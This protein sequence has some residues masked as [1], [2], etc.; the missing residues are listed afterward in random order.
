[1]ID[2]ERL[3]EITYSVPVDIGGGSGFPKVAVMAA[4]AEFLGLTTYIEVGVYRGRSFLPL[5]W[6]FAQRGGHSIAVDPYSRDEADEKGLPDDIREAVAAFIA[7][8]DW[9]SVYDEFM[10]RRSALE[11]D[12]STTVFRKASSAAFPLVAEKASGSMMIHID[13]NHDTRC[14]MEDVRRYMSLM[15]DGDVLVLDDTDWESVK[16]ALGYAQSS[17]YTIHS[18]DTFTILTRLDRDVSRRIRKLR[19]KCSEYDLCAQANVF[20]VAPEKRP[21]V[22]VSMI[23]YNQEKYVA[24]AI[25]SALAQET[26]FPYEIVIGEDAST[27]RTRDIC[28]E[29]QRAR[30]DKIRLLEREK[31]LGA[32]ANYLETYKACRGEFVA[33]LEGDDFWIDKKKLQRQVDFLR[34][35]PDYAISCHNVYLADDAGVL[36]APLLSNIADTTTVR[37][38]C[39][40]D[41]IA[42]ASC[43][44]RNE[45]VKSVPEWLYHLP[46]CDWVFDIL[47]AECGKIK[48]FPEPMA[49][50]RKHDQGIWSGYSEIW[51]LSIAAKMVIEVNHHLDYRYDREF[52]TYLSINR[53][54]YQEILAETLLMAHSP[55]GASVRGKLDAIHDLLFAVGQELARLS[56]RFDR[57]DLA[58]ARLKSAARRASSVPR[59]MLTRR[60]GA[61]PSTRARCD[62]VIVDDAYPHPQSAFRAAEFDAY[63]TEFSNAVAFTTGAAFSFFDDARSREDIINDHISKQS[64]FRGRIIGCDSPPDV[65]ARLGYTVFLGNTWLNVEYF[66]RNRIPFV[67]TL[68]PGGAFRVGVPE[69]DQML[70][71]VFSSEMFRRVI[72][73]QTYTRDYLVS[74]QFVDSSKIDLI[75]GV[76]TPLIALESSNIERR[77]FGFEKNTLDIC[78]TAHKY[79][80]DGHDK[81]YDIFLD[82][83]RKLVRA[84]PECRFHVVGGFSADDLP[85][86]GL[87]GKIFFYGGREPAWFPTFYADKDLILLCNVPFVLRDGAFDG[88]PTGTGVDALLQEVSLF[89]TDPLK[90]NAYFAEDKDIVIVPHDADVI[91]DRIMW[92]R[93]NPAALREIGKNGRKKALE[94]YSYEAQIAPRLEILKR[95]IGSE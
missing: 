37:D 69:S 68:Y 35:N 41:Y 76:V 66:E 30:P 21:V 45:Q 36:G 91:V 15:A 75:Y 24:Q 90:M 44:I 82:V 8:T 65:A 53:L 11:L 70:R 92:Y 87:E 89:C 57:L 42:T 93:A 86:D 84:A 83:A 16:P 12:A 80:S 56:R 81:G 73:T 25:Q 79:M 34:A 31:N 20:S 6:S 85:V 47:N 55:Q 61:R 58:W 4:L 67:F 95:E 7:T 14:V 52:G 62:L 5:A 28:R 74:G 48:Y 33:F 77:K 72:V 46:G 71:R 26:D 43:M 88:F 40:G 2:L 63:L 22:S 23:T 64:L 60:R 27:D 59:V 29:F 19:E 54:R 94:L 39:T 17:L 9:D 50:Y 38:L 78:F 3:C 13:G 10:G 49:A 32:V 1:M 51:Q 18:A